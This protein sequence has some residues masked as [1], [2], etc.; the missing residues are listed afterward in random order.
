[1]C[2]LNLSPC[3]GWRQGEAC[4]PVV[5]FV[6]HVIMDRQPCTCC[7]QLFD[8][9]KT[10]SCCI[11]KK[12]YSYACMQLSTAEARRINAKIGISWTCP[13]C[14]DLGDDLNALKAAIVGLREQIAALQKS[15][16][17]KSDLLRTEEIIQEVADRES[18]K[19]NII[20]FNLPEDVTA[21]GGGL[22]AADVGA[23][24]DILAVLEAP[25][26]SV[27]PIRLG[28]FDPSKPERCRPLKVSLP[29]SRIIGKILRNN[30]KLKST[31]KFKAVYVGKDRTPFQ[32]NLYRTVRREYL[33][34]REAGE[35]DIVMKYIKDVPTIT[36]INQ[37]N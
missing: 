36:K 16:T 14:I 12:A 6:S 10:V 17:T 7:G 22:A 37:G 13:T 29:D 23:V 1:M 3:D 9:H 4:V 11:C 18:R 21:G 31:D 32:S 25:A 2:V 19:N 5:P 34:R 33:D 35:T 8:S 28:K 27:K 20:I 15:G 26:V 30:K 24:G